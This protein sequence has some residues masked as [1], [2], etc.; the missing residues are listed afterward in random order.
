VN[1]SRDTAEAERLADQ[2][3]AAVT[4]CPSVVRLAEGPV[5]T[6]LPGRAVRGVALREGEVRVAVVA[7]YGPP[8]TD[9]AEQ[10]RAAVRRAAPGLRVDVMIEDIDLPDDRT[11]EP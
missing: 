10:V 8:L 11:G 5:A 4:G 9:I 6:Y 7:A 2:V 1:F 3:A